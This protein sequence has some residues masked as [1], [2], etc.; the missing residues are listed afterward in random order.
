MM[1]YLMMIPFRST[2]GT[3]SHETL[4]LVEPVLCPVTFCGAPSG[5]NKEMER[6]SL[7]IVSNNPSTK[8]RQDVQQSA[9]EHLPQPFSS[10][11][12]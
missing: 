1:V 10:R 4:I 8:G 3:S 6:L 5:S 11:M 12:T 9:C 7:V 2:T